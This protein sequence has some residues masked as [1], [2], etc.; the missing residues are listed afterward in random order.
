M[1]CAA[2]P[3]LR[4]EARRVRQLKHEVRQLVAR[5][6]GG[7]ELKPTRPDLKRHAVW[8]V[9]LSL[10]PPH[11]PAAE[12]A[13]SPAATQKASAIAKHMPFDIQGWAILPGQPDALVSLSRGILAPGRVTDGSETTIVVHGA[14][15]LR[16]AAPD[17]PGYEPADSDAS[18]PRDVRIVPPTECSNMAY[19]TIAGQPATGK[20]LIGFLGSA[21]QC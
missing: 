8:L 19:N 18:M 6:A 12:A 13:T 2:T 15:R 17:M 1:I 9:L 11:P 10:M 14:R 5:Y 4:V 7:G 3:A 16:F 21:A 20:D